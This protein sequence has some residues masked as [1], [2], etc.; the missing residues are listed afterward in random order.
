MNLRTTSYLFAI[1]LCFSIITSTSATEYREPFFSHSTTSSEYYSIHG[2]ITIDSDQ[3]FIDY[4][5]TGNGSVENPYRIERLNITSNVASGRAISIQ[6]THAVFVIRDCVIQS[7]YIGIAV[8]D[9]AA[10]TAFIVNNTLTSL[11]GDGGGI[12]LQ[13]VNCTVSEN[14]CN[15]W[16]Q[17]IHLNQASHCIISRNNISDSTYQ[18]INIRYSDNNT[19]INNRIFNST[20]HGLLFV[21]TSSFNVAYNNTFI[22][23]GN[24]SEYTVDNDRIG[25]LN[26]Q[27]YDEGSD[28]I[29]Y[30]ID[31]KTGNVW[32]D[33][34][35][36]GSYAIDGPANSF[37]LY[38]ISSQ[39]FQISALFVPILIISGLVIVLIALVYQR[40]RR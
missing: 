10:G 20:Q 6:N 5:F 17:G 35:G 25:T 2:P 31:S 18:G 34:S 13:T 28:N 14:R 16:A 23:N 19:I 30:D 7:Q 24:T 27:G 4:G 38:P 8:L 36:H 22:N 33:Y 12:L 32:N 11:F 15:S 1:L 3:D 9:V 39:S 26:S 21:G 40:L 29:W 37:D